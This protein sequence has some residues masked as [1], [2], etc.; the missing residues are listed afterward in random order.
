MGMP[1]IDLN[2]RGDITRR[3]S[4]NVFKYLQNNKRRR[5]LRSCRLMRWW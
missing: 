5:Y 3:Q 4:M 2:C 1:G